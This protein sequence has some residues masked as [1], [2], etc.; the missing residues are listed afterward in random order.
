VTAD[1]AVLVTVISPGVTKFLTK[2]KDSNS[3][4]AKKQAGQV[5]SE[6]F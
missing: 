2:K 3:S 6:R 1:P 4:D 5:S